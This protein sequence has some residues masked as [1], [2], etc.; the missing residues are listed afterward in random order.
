MTFMMKRDLDLT[1]KR[2]SNEEAQHENL[3]EEAV[4]S[5]VPPSY[6]YTM[7][8]TQRIDH[9]KM[10]ENCQPPNSNSSMAKEIHVYMLLTS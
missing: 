7:T 8:Y 1:G 3:Q 9:L 4:E 5:V 2:P 6:T 10:L